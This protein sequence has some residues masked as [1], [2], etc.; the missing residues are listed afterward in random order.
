MTEAPSFERSGDERARARLRRNRALATGLLGLMA[1]VFAGTHFIAD[2]G[3]PTLLL[4]AATE[5]GVVG[6]LADWFAV[7]ALFRRPLGLPIPHTAIIP[8]NK[9]RI[10][11]TLGRFV[12][13]NFLT[14]E[15]VTARIRNAEAARRLAQWAAQP[16]IAAAIADSVTAGLPYV[17]R[18]LNNPDLHDFLSRTLGEELRKA[19][20]APVIGRTLELLLRSGEVDPLFDQAMAAAME[21]LDRNRGRFEALV[22]ERSRWWI[23]KAI[24]RRIAAVLVNGTIELLSDL[25]QEDSQ[26]RRDFR[27]ALDRLIADLVQSAAH[28]ER[29]NGL[30][31]RLLDHPEMKAWLSS[32][33]QEL[34]R[35]VLDDLERPG[36]RTRAA[37]ETAVAT[38]TRAVAGDSAMQR[39]ID[40]LFERLAAYLVRW[41]STIGAFISDV[42]K[43]WDSKAL[44]SRL[45]LVVGSDLQ[46]I[47][48]NGT[49][50]GAIVGCVLFLAVHL[51]GSGQ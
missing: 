15:A 8:A 1:A 30:K 24:D 35:I 7:T 27:S 36:S 22:E 9:D 39:H 25:R 4:R 43:G 20:I 6:G 18:S 42:V 16:E 51:L 47:R 2:P 37:I 46:Y 45:E 3:I 44:S 33:W 10:A 38:I 26:A 32:V 19:D 28:R 41:R 13:R 23:P 29:L 48:M 21:W 12:E 49:I 34:A 11:A 50:V 40:S 5:A 14:E 31:N 17:V